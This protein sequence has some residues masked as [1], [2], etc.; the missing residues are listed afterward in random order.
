MRR[1][2]ASVVVIL[3]ERMSWRANIHDRQIKALSRKASLALCIRHL[4]SIIRRMR[5]ALLRSEANERAI[6]DFV[7]IL[8]LRNK[9]AANVFAWPC[10]RGSVF[11]IASEARKYEKHGLYFKRSGENTCKIIIIHHLTLWF[12]IVVIMKADVCGEYLEFLLFPFLR[13]NRG[14][15]RG[16]TLT[17]KH[18]IWERLEN[19]NRESS[20]VSCGRA[21]LCSSND[22]AVMALSICPSNKYAFAFY[23]L[24]EKF[25]WHFGIV[26][27]LKWSMAL[28]K[29]RRNVSS[30]RRNHPKCYIFCLSMVVA[31]NTNESSRTAILEKHRRLGRENRVTLSKTVSNLCVRQNTG[32]AG[33]GFRRR[34]WLA[35]VRSNLAFAWRSISNYRSSPSCLNEIKQNLRPVRRDWGFAWHCRGVVS[36]GAFKGNNL[37]W[38]Y[39]AIGSDDVLLL[40]GANRPVLA[41]PASK[42]AGKWWYKHR[43]SVYNYK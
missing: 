31:P 38:A 29:C 41:W 6:D 43:W 30:S 25:L 26:L 42:E 16:N 32:V 17:S 5:A 23:A 2:I 4:S 19:R 7:I 9:H 11:N 34:G 27:G 33:R 13:L 10:A 14:A 24:E 1:H 8:R 40:N 15:V 3:R 12:S 18:P 28:D 22:M 39:R 37:S 21:G 35:A 20:P 36:G